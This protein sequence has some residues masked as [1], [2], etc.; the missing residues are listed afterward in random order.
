MWDNY[1]LEDDPFFIYYIILSFMIQ[2]RNSILVFDSTLLMETLPALSINR[3]EEM[4]EIIRQAKVYDKNTPYWFRKTCEQ[5]YSYWVKNVEF[6]KLYNALDTLPCLYVYPE[7]IVWQSYSS[8]RASEEYKS[9]IKYVILDCRP[10]EQIK[11]CG[12]IP[13]AYVFNP[14]VTDN[15]KSLE[16]LLSDFSKMKGVHFCLMGSEDKDD[17]K[18]KL[19]LITEQFI[20]A[21]FAHI[22]IVYGGYAACHN[23]LLNRRVEIMDHAIDSCSICNPIGSAELYPVDSFGGVFSKFFNNNQRSSSFQSHFRKGSIAIRNSFINLWGGSE[24]NLHPYS[25][26]QYQHYHPHQRY[27][28]AITDRNIQS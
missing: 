6:I 11:S 28:S 4:E 20:K 21:N 14:D 10:E 23:V 26:G 5:I 27:E 25:T 9:N 13:T 19:N 8:S 15:A 17:S 7:E 18:I 24:P 16:K 12:R 3:V 22:S 2:N 1:L